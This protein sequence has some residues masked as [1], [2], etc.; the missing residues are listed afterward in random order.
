MHIYIHI[1]IHIYVLKHIHTFNTH[2]YIFNT[3]KANCGLWPM[4]GRRLTGAPSSAGGRPGSAGQGWARCL[5]GVASWAGG[6]GEL[7]G[8]I[9]RRYINIFTCNKLNAA[10]VN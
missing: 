9:I 10:G 8:V 4:G 5:P 7:V 2:M 1:F 3:S 6:Q